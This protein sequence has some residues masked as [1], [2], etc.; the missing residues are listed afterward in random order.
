M[1][2]LT[3]ANPIDEN[4]AKTVGQNFL[5]GK[6]SSN[7]KPNLKLARRV[8]LERAKTN[9]DTADGAFYIFNVPSSQGFVIVSASDN[10]TPILGYS[11]TGS[12][13]PDSINP[14]CKAWLNNYK[15]QIQY[16]INNNLQATEKIKD[17]WQR[18]QNS[19]NQEATVIVAPLIRTNWDQGQYY[20]AVCPSDNNAPAG[21]DNRCPTGCAATAMAQI[22]KYWEY[23][24][25]GN[26][27]HSYTPKTHPEY[28]EQTANFGN[29]TYDWKNTPYVVNDYN[30]N[31]AE[32]LFHC[33]VAVDMEYD[34][35]ESRS[36]SDNTLSAYKE[37][38]RFNPNS[39]GYAVR[40]NKSDA[41]WIKI[42][43]DE[44]DKKMPMEYIA[45]TSDK[46]ESGHIWICDGYDDSNKFHMNWGW[47]GSG[48][49]WFPTEALN[50]IITQPNGQQIT[51]T[52][53]F[54]QSVIG[55]IQP[56]YHTISTSSNP[57]ES[58]IISG[59]GN[60]KFG[61][62]C[63]LTATANSE[64]K[65]AYWSNTIGNPISTSST[66]S[67]TVRSDTTIIAN[68][69]MEES[70]NIISS[71]NPS[72]GGTITGSGTYSAGSS[73][74]L[75]A[76]ANSDYTFVNW[77]ENGTE[78]STN[79]SYTFTVSGNRTLVAN[80]RFTT[81]TGTVTDIDGN[82]YHTVTIG[83][84]T[85]MVENLK[86]TRYCNG[87]AISEQWAYNN[88]ENNVAKYGRLYTWN[89][90]TDSRG[91]APIGWHV[92]TDA[93]WSTLENYL[94][95]NGYNYDGT[96]TGNKI[97]KALAATTDWIT[98]GVI[99]SPGN[100]LTT[101]NSSGFTALPG[102]YCEGMGR[103][104]ILSRL[105]GHWWSSTEYNID[106]VWGR[107]LSYS[108]I[109]LS[110]SNWFSK[111]FGYSVR[112]IKDAE[113]EIPTITTNAISNITLSSATSGGSINSDGGSP[114]TARGVCWNTTGNPTIADSK[115]SDGSGLSVFTS[116]M[117]GLTAAT[118]YYVR[119]YAT[120]GVGTGYGEE[121][122]FT[123]Y[124]GQV[125]DIDG[126]V[127]HTVTIGTQTWM[128][129][130]LKTTRYRNGDLIGTTTPATKD[131]YTETEPKYQWAYDG[132]DNNAA[133]YGRL[134]TWYA[135]TDSRGI[136]PVGWHVPTDAEWTMLANYLIANG[137]NYDGTTTGNKIAKAMAATTDWVT[138]NNIGTIG[139]DLTKNNSSGFTGLPGGY[140]DSNNNLYNI[141]TTGKFDDI[142]YT[143]NW[144]SSTERTSYN[145]TTYA[146]YSNLFYNFSEFERIGDEQS[147][148]YSVRCLKD[149]EAVISINVAIPGTL[150]RLLS[151]EQLLTIGNLKITGN[152]DARDFK[153][154]R[155]SMP[156]LN[157]L[158]LKEV[159]ISSYF[160]IEGT[161][162]DNRL[163]PSNMIPDSAFVRGGFD[164]FEQFSSI[165]LPDALE[166]I[167]YAS[168][169]ASEI[170]KITIP[171]TG[172]KI[173]IGNYAFA[174]CKLLKQIELLTTKIPNISSLTFDYVDKSNCK[175]FVPPG[176]EN[177]YRNAEY[178]KEFININEFTTIEENIN[179]R[180][181]SVS[182]I[183]PWVPLATS[184]QITVYKDIN[185]TQ[186]IEQ[187]LIYKPYPF[188]VNKNISHIQE[189]DS[190]SL[191][192]N[193]N[194]M[195]MNPIK[196]YVSQGTYPGYEI[197]GLD[198][199]TTYYYTLLAYDSD[200]SVLAMS[201]GEFSTTGTITWIEPISYE[202]EV[203]LYPNPVKK[204]L[205][206]KTPSK[207][208]TIK[209]Y[210][211]QGSLLKTIPA[212]QSHDQIDV[213]TL[214]S[215]VYMVK[216]S[217]PDGK[218]YTGKFVKE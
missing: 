66:Y 69:S 141:N 56:I 166:S 25:N 11:Y 98:D 12:I 92:P 140:R 20:N 87:D 65:F 163:Y 144:W 42:L 154:L 133:K 103:F 26:G 159:I 218:V 110:R 134:Y 16:V 60:F 184:Y 94:I 173:S 80:F 85:W 132:E 5:F 188:G 6:S 113:A 33:G 180:I 131:I 82:I 58:G 143:C 89:A 174:S 104:D 153:T 17:Q 48:N 114:I 216:I 43:K 88:D 157:K 2:N 125:T 22:M 45:L 63:T 138:S 152:I 158:N 148:G 3:Y 72:E 167:G 54:N 215:G 156:N 192:V 162:A 75:T 124:T 165:I 211:L 97:A 34:P 164:E 146:V 112:C 200:N 41:D 186:V 70:Y 175:L 62:T 204:V 155:F 24:I 93:E 102:G 39:I 147:I 28:G 137:Y 90:A 77:T 81:N 83:T 199:S 183:W 106:Y 40:E 101:N 127:Y 197:S 21:Y 59:S 139:N 169:C 185:H 115:T 23:P 95:A 100:D 201:N 52:Y 191:D 35:K 209:I 71:A 108:N 212:Y 74:T 181:N 195:K 15:E 79:A 207:K 36:N 196:S 30:D 109:G 168:F 51:Y 37:Y 29:T 68:F 190:F 31:V 145:G 32:L 129:E 213:S 214:Q 53:N 179:T 55:G 128:A 150:S 91:I 38:F 217:G 57:T 13:D 136:A 118:T 149:D 187:S 96:T 130:N 123:T 18:I 50:P 203:S 160:G 19:T 86:T 119:A 67:F 105:G 9:I 198:P 176:S 107:G 78:V 4:T 135:A 193:S 121:V 61:E 122:R 210:S 182:F 8:T 27:T 178:W 73:C 189:I 116:T 142:G 205:Y 111:W 84:Q 177:A 202:N 170:S 194:T 44:L 161:C 64:Y 10:V 14:A 172:Y 76:T 47:G 1:L 49:G 99:G 208:S 206:I 151:D 171:D 126:N 46:A 120:N 7:V 117:T